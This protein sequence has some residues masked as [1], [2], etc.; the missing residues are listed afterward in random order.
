MVAITCIVW[1]CLFIVSGLCRR[2]LTITASWC[3][4]TITA[5][6]LLSVTR[7][8]LTALLT[9]TSRSYSTIPIIN[10]SRTVLRWLTIT[11]RH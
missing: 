11:L 8:R 5:S 9:I 2:V 1:S 4:L 10:W 6:R 7:N 3:R